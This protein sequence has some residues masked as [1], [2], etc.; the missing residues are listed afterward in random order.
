MTLSTSLFSYSF[1][2]RPAVSRTIATVPI[3]SVNY[4]DVDLLRHYLSATGKILPRRAVKS[5]S[6]KEHRLVAKAIRRA[7]RIGILPFVW[8]TNLTFVFLNLID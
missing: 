1:S 2:T 4:K 5:I 7:R 8:L 6:K 3:R